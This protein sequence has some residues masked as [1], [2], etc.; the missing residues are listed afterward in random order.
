MKGGFV[1]IFD[2]RLNKDNFRYL[3]DSFNSSSSP[4]KRNNALRETKGGMKMEG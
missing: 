2:I 4:R 1:Q 3:I